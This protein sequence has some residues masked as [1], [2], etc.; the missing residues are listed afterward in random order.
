MRFAFRASNG[1][2]MCAE[3]GGGRE[4]VANRNEIELFP[5]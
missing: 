4:V 5:I 1:K 3:G 2:Y